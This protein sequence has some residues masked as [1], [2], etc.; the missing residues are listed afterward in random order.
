MHNM[1]EPNLALGPCAP[2]PPSRFHDTAEIT[3]DNEL[4]RL[5][6]LDDWTHKQVHLFR[7]VSPAGARARQAALSTIACHVLRSTRPSM[8]VQAMIHPDGRVTYRPFLRPSKP[9]ADP[10]NPPARG[11][12]LRWLTTRPWAGLTAHGSRL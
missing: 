1:I 11:R 2:V 12:A 10:L 9:L 3:R 7:F 4:N 8:N 5:T 6:R